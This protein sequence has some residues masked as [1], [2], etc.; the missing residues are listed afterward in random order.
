MEAQETREA[1]KKKTNQTQRGGLCEVSFVLILI[2]TDLLSGAAWRCS[3]L[4]LGS[5][6]PKG[7]ASAG[8]PGLS[9]SSPDNYQAES[10]RREPGLSRQPESSQ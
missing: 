10:L 4:R 1:C 7:K 5:R 9:T 6:V 3:P 2:S 8:F